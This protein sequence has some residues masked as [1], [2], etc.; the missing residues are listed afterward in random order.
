M[1]LSSIG[2]ALSTGGVSEQ[3]DIGVLNAVQNLEQISSAL[4]FASIGIGTG[5]DASA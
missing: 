4:L 3:I 1:D 5:V 2:S